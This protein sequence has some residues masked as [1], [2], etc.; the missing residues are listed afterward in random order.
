MKSM[1]ARLL[2]GFVG[3]V[4]V[5]AFVIA[6][7]VFYSTRNELMKANEEHLLYVS[8]SIASTIEEMNEKEYK[9]L[10]TIAALPLIQ[11]RDV[12][13]EEKFNAVTA[14][15]EQDKSYIDVTILTQDGKAIAGVNGKFIDFSE[16][17][18]YKV[19]MTGSRYVTDPFINKVSNAMAQFYALPVYDKK[20]QIINVVFSVID[21]YRM[22]DAIK[23][24][25]IGHDSHPFAI[26]RKT[27]KV[28]AAADRAVLDDGG[29]LTFM[30]GKDGAN[31]FA[32][33]LGESSGFGYYKKGKVDMVAFYHAVPDTDWTIFA[34]A[35]VGDFQGGIK[36][37]M[38]II[39]VL[40][41][42]M[43]VAVATVA[44]IL[45]SASLKPLIAARESVMQIATG[46]ADLTKR[47]DFST[48]DEIGA[49]L[50]G[51]NAFT[52]KLQAIIGEIKDSKGDLLIFGER[53][54][55]MAQSNSTFVAEM[56]D[57]VASVA[58]ELNTQN[59]KVTG[60]VEAVQLISDSIKELRIL[61]DRQ[62]EGVEA[63]SS[64]VTQM[65]SSIESV[66][67]SVEMM[68]SRFGTLKNNVHRGIDSEKQVNEL[69][70]KVEEQ[71]KTLEEANVVISDIA[72][73][74]N[75]LAMNA[76]IEAAHAGEQGKG[77]AVV[78][79]EIRKLSESSSTQSEAISSQVSLILTSINTLA[80]VSFESDEVFGEVSTGIEETGG[81]V[82]QIKDAITEQ[83][84]GSKQITAVLSGMDDAA[85]DVRT[86]SGNVDD[87]RKRIKSNI[88]EM[89]QSSQEVEKSLQSITKG[90][91][92]IASG[93]DNLMNIATEINGS[94]YRINAQ[95]DQFK[96]G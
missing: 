5:C 76:S 20:G 8:Q 16:R 84:A 92:Q 25:T 36:S 71:S 23:G 1:R 94:I 60:S 70:Q 15:K 90:V 79:D 57:S 58:D 56:V 37:M 33:G 29:D 86:A 91:D 47:V 28:V 55:H 27:L 31:S 69:I 4:A 26:N 96:V 2:A 34:A 59:S 75:L 93:N 65:I 24:I 81:L 6:G 49:V 54:S 80:D 35:P 64:A 89:A 11:D 9:L 38:R 62:E 52:E 12:S 73:Q 32:N 43:F 39:I 61:L 74:T 85:K 66:S 68:T 88:E 95:I 45:V 21:G 46:N 7:I 14:V 77:F 78:A 42:I 82:E 50:K 87:E 72:E 3:A 63:A 13:I 22:C 18:Y 19:P 67:R 53:L 51:I 48:N 10:T 17:A 30:L 40:F 83:T 41:I 44:T